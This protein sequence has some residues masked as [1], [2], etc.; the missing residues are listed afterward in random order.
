MGAIKN[1]LIDLAEAT[2]VAAYGENNTYNW[3][4]YT[5]EQIDMFRE[6]LLSW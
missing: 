2:C 4:R 3:K 6:F 5:K 1:F